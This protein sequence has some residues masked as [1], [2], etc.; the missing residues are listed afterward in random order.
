MNV[1]KSSIA[2]PLVQLSLLVAVL[3][4]GHASFAGEKG[5]EKA[6]KYWSS[7]Y[8]KEKAGDLQGAIADFS[9]AIK[10]DPAYTMAYRSRASA[11]IKT[12]DYDGAIADA[13]QCIEV[14]GKD[15]SCYGVRGEAYKAKGDLAHAE[16]DQKRVS[17]AAREYIARDAAIRASARHYTDGEAI[18]G[19]GT[20]MG[21]VYILPDGGC[22]GGPGSGIHWSS[23]ARMSFGSTISAQ[24]P[25]RLVPA[26]SP[27]TR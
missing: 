27:A 7:G 2:R 24:S 20:A 9:K 5:L 3:S 4:F 21:D 6:M 10:A 23:G 26:G 18:P 22:F 17:D 1:F 19:V 14:D 25:I 15:T 12:A 13:T 11:K 16:S 8:E